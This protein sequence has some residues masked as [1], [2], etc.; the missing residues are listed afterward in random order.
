[1]VPFKLYQNRKF[2]FEFVENPNLNLCY[3]FFYFVLSGIAGV[4]LGL[5][6]WNHYLA[7]DSSSF[8]IHIVVASAKIITFVSLFFNIWS[9]KLNLLN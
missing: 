2:F 1:M 8:P 6:I 9:I 4:E 5:A 7:Y 3:Q